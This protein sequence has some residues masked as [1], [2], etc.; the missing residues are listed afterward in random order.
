MYQLQNVEISIPTMK[1]MFISDFLCLFFLFFIFVHPMN[2]CTFYY[3]LNKVVIY[4]KFGIK[5]DLQSDLF[6]LNQPLQVSPSRSN[7]TQTYLSRPACRSGDPIY[8]NFE[9]PDRIW[10]LCKKKSLL[11][12]FQTCALF[13]LF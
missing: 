1:S 6:S 2:L 9:E 5:N 7:L 12:T 13:R 8:T 3:S 10:Y 4:R 11:I